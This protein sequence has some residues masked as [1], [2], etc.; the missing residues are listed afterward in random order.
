MNKNYSCCRIDC[1]GVCGFRWWNDEACNGSSGD[2]WRRYSRIFLAY[3]NAAVV[4][5][6]YCG[7]GELITYLN[8]R[9][10]L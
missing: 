3:V 7:S 5:C 2:D 6:C 1:C 10:R 8:G 9:L 4:T